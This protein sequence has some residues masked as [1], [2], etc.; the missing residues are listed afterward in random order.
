MRDTPSALI[1]SSVASRV[2]G[3]NSSRGASK[4]TT[5]RGEAGA[6]AGAASTAASSTASRDKMRRGMRVVRDE[7][8]GA[9]RARALKPTGSSG[10]ALPASLRSGV[11][12]AIVDTAEQAAA[13]R[14]APL[15][16][17][18]PLEA[19]LDAN[20]LGHGAVHA[21]PIGEGH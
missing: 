21:E 5:W 16:V 12:G 14:L 7:N 18:R 6:V 19:F 1:S 13:L 2:A 11:V 10:V 15:L 17:R 9:R 20:G 4:E 3:S 8:Q